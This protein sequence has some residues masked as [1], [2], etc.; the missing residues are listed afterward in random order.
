[1]VIHEMSKLAFAANETT[2]KVLAL[3]S[4]MPGQE[5]HT[6][7]IARRTGSLPNAAQRALTRSLEHGLLR[8]RRVGNLRMWSMDQ[9]N[10][11]YASIRE[12]FARTYG[13]PARLAEVLKKHGRV[14]YAFLFGSYVTAQDDP[15]S[16]I[17]LF[18]VGEPDWVSLAGAVREAGHQL[19]REVNAVVWT[20]DD[21]DRPTGTQ[22]SFL[23]TLT[24]SPMMWLLGDRSQFERRARVGR[25]GGRRGRATT[26]RSI[27]HGR[28]GARA[29]RKGS[30]QGRQSAVRGGKPR[31]RARAG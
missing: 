8:S 21:V 1:M 17:D 30:R 31:Q 29:E 24:S 27:A 22:R 4:S 19:G 2:A 16:D 15:T 23:D 13:V 7:E 12:T 26:Q 11:L 20:E 6:N 28:E 18:I 14:K 25:E 5:L 9:T 3:L 10:P